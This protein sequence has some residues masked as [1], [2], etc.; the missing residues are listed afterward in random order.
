MRRR[1][2]LAAFGATALQYRT[3]ILGRHARAKSMGLGAASV[4]R[5]KGPLRHRDDSLRAM[6]TLSVAARRYDVK[7]ALGPP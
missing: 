4:V 2:T 6:K 5:L 1:Q 3:A 7:E